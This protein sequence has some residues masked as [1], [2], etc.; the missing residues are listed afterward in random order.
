LLWSSARGLS[1]ALCDFGLIGHA[2]TK[3]YYNYNVNLYWFPKIGF[4]LCVAGFG[5]DQADLK[6]RKPSDACADALFD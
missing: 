1:G 4:S 3:Q 5:A 6:R 2:P